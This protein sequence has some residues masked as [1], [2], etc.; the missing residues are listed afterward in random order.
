MLSSRHV[1]VIWKL[2]FSTA[3]YVSLSVVS[4]MQSGKSGL[5]SNFGCFSS[6]NTHA[7]RASVGLWD[8]GTVGLEIR[9]PYMH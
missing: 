4:F 9:T 5:V 3:L 8:C 7:C 6:S 2:L 1:V